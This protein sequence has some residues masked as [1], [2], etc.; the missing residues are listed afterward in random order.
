[1]GQQGQQAARSTQGGA[2]RAEPGMGRRPAL[3]PHP[4]RTFWPTLAFWTQPIQVP[5]DMRVLPVATVCPHPRTAGPPTC[6]SCPSCPGWTPGTGFAR[7]PLLPCFW[8]PS[9]RDP[10]QRGSR[11]SPTCPRH[12]RSAGHSFVRR[13]GRWHCLTAAPG[14]WSPSGRS[15]GSRNC[16]PRRQFPVCGPHHVPRPHLKPWTRHPCL[17]DL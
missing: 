11:P 8:E 15:L 14:A 1:M 9:E 17:K 13:P 16:M 2:Q 7:M 3:S 5:P 12:S 4:A 6:D 10:A